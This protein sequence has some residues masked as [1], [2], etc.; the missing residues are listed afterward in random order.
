MKNIIIVLI[1]MFLSFKK[2]F[3]KNAKW[4][5]PFIL[6]L[7]TIFWVLISN[8]IN[9][10]LYW[11]KSLEIYSKIIKDILV[12][13]FTFL[14]IIITLPTIE[15]EN[16]R[17]DYLE[18]LK[19]L[20]IS[21]ITHK[22]IIACFRFF[23]K[24]WLNNIIT[25]DIVNKY[26]R[27]IEIEKIKITNW[28]FSNNLFYNKVKQQDYCANTWK[29]DKRVGGNIKFLDKNFERNAIVNYV[30]YYS[31]LYT[32][33]SQIKLLIPIYITNDSSLNKN[34]TLNSDNKFS[35]NSLEI[36]DNNNDY[37]LYIELKNIISSFENKIYKKSNKSSVE[38]MLYINNIIS[39][40]NRIIRKIE[41]SNIN[42]KKE[43]LFFNEYNEDFI[44]L[45]NNLFNLYKKYPEFILTTYFEYDYLLSEWLWS[46][47]QKIQYIDDINWKKYYTL[48]NYK[49]YK[50]ELK[51]IVWK[52]KKE[53]L[54]KVDIWKLKI[55]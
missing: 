24:Q 53:W 38:V 32:K 18:S 2:N 19:I 31:K 12:P 50:K 27:I 6:T 28:Y 39:I 54:F 15:K 25:P 48:N 8:D 37:F 7:L 43:W 42:N 52:F 14:L 10:N 20:N 44:Y 47:K 16:I 35:I 22:A 9:L 33:L 4:F 51:K 41:Q 5:L 29:Y 49:D 21:H 17:L 36:D 34:L 55:F 13:L 26:D 23:E 40:L 30:T 3:N 1:E 46:L 45:A 11:W